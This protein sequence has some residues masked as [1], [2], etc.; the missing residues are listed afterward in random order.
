MRSLLISDIIFSFI[1]E[2]LNN[3]LMVS[4]LGREIF[5]VQNYLIKLVGWTQYVP[6][7]AI[8]SL[9]NKFYE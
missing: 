4:F 9:F 1:D 6:F 7:W 5:V 2:V 8:V 3:F